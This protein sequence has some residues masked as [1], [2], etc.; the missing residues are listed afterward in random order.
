M[1]ISLDQAKAHLNIDPS[2]TDDDTYLT[3]LIETVEIIIENDINR[4]ID[5]V[6]LLFDSVKATKAIQ[7]AAKILMAT[8]YANREATIVGVRM[9]KAPLSYEHII[10]NYKTYTVG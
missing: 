2:F 3:E 10:S 5:E 7:H 8:L 9:E 1:I 4:S 6:L